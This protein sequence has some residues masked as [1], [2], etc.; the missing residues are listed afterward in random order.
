M[1]SNSS[2]V[3]LSFDPLSLSSGAA[4][5]PLFVTLNFIFYTLLSAIVVL[6]NG[7]YFSGHL[8]AVRIFSCVLDV[9]WFARR[10]GGVIFARMFLE[11]EHGDPASAVTAH[12]FSRFFVATL[13]CCLIA[14]MQRL[15]DA[16]VGVRP[17]G[18]SAGFQICPLCG[19]RWKATPHCP[20]AHRCPLLAEDQPA[21]ESGSVN[22]GTITDGSVAGRRNSPFP[23]RDDASFLS[24]CTF[25]WL[26]TFVLYASQAPSV[27]TSALM[28]PP[29]PVDMP[30]LVNIAEPVIALWEKKADAYTLASLSTAKEER[31]DDDSDTELLAPSYEAR[32][33]EKSTLPRAL[34]RGG[35]ARRSFPLR[36]ARRLLLRPSQRLFGRIFQRFFLDAPLAATPAAPISAIPGASLFSVFLSSRGGARFMKCIPLKVA[37]DLLSFASPILV[38][39]LVRFVK[40]GS[41]ADVSEGLLICIT[42]FAVLSLQS[43]VFQMY[44]ERLYSAAQ[45]AA[46][47]AKALVL[48]ACLSMPLDQ[49]RAGGTEGDAIACVAVEASRAGDTLVFLHNAWGH[50]MNIAIGLIVLKTYVGYFSSLCT[51]LTVLLMIPLN[52]RNAVR[53]Q[54]AQKAAKGTAPRVALLNEALSQ[55]RLI[56]ANA[57]EDQMLEKVLRARRDE[58]D[59]EVVIHKA[60]AAATF[61]VEAST[62]AIA[63]VCFASYYAAGG[64]LVAEAL[65]PALA[66]IN[67]LKFPIWSFPNLF[68]TISRGYV[69]MLRLQNFLNGRTKRPSLQQG[70]LPRGEV[71]C[72]GGTFGWTAQ[73]SSSKASV[74]T[75][76][77]AAASSA[78]AKDEST[79]VEVLRNVC[80]AIRP[81][82]KVAVT[83]KVAAGKSTL[84]MSMLGESASLSVG[85][86]HGGSVAL[87][88][89][90]PWLRND[91]IRSNIVMN[92]KFVPAWYRKVVFAC[93]LVPDLERLADGDLSLVG[94]K[95]VQLS[96]GQKARIGLARA[97][98]HKADIY[99][100]DGVLAALDGDTQRHII[101]HVWNGL[102]AEKTVVMA[103]HVCVDELRAD[104]LLVVQ[105]GGGIEIQPSSAV[106][107]AGAAAARDLRSES[108]DDEV[109]SSPTAFRHPVRQ[110]K[111]GLVSHTVPN[112]SAPGQKSSKIANSEP[113]ASLKSMMWKYAKLFRWHA[114][115]IVLTA[116]VQQAAQTGMDVWLGLWITRRVTT[117][118][119]FLIVYAVLGVI[120]AFLSYLRSRIFFTSCGRVS[121]AM[122]FSA[123]SR[124][125]RAPVSYFDKAVTGTLANVLSKDQDTVD[126][127]VP[128]SVELLLLSTL[129]LGAIAIF[130]S[131]LNPLFLIVIPLSVI[132]F[133]RVSTMFLAVSREVRRLEN[134]SVAGTVAI[135]REALLGSVTI[136][137]LGL[138]PMILSEFCEAM[139]VAS[140]ANYIGV[141]LDRWVGLRLELVS[142]I[143]A[144]TAAVV[145]VLFNE[146]VSPAF[147]GVAVVNCLNTS[148]TLLMLC[149]RMGTFQVQFMAVEQ[150]LRL[151]EVPAEPVY[152]SAPASF[153]S[154]AG[155]FSTLFIASSSTGAAW[156]ATS[157]IRFSR[158]SCKYHSADSSPN[159]LTDLTLEIPPCSKIGIVGRSG[160]GKSTVFNAILRLVD[161]IDGE[162][163]LG[164]VPARS[165]DYRLL[166]RGVSIIPQEP[167]ILRGT[168]RENL[169]LDGPSSAV[170]DVRLWEALEQVSLRRKVEAC[171]GGLDSEMGE[172]GSNLSSGEKQ[173][174]CLARASLRQSKF[175]LL[176]EVTASVDE[177]TDRYIQES[178]QKHFV[179]CTILTIAHRV[180]TLQHCDAVLVM[181][182][183]GTLKATVLP[184]E[185][186]KQ[187]SV[188]HHDVE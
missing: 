90:Q 88:T 146:S 43:I 21:A 8:S 160:T 5:S 182:E 142:I 83:G 54:D 141:S 13:A 171:P 25:W 124:L 133:F 77:V 111:L 60:E 51:F 32:Q 1:S 126:H 23:R 98:Y 127:A 172:G 113:R 7:G 91:S 163:E 102:L 12:Y 143:L 78:S 94:D 162:I 123:C 35:A 76:T 181:G 37:Q 75:S 9:A 187:G 131:A 153:S 61:L 186:L 180:K 184:K 118:V 122:H 82:E 128:E 173:L 41:S 34:K 49:Q 26:N 4:S 18:F 150:V 64:E 140:Q 114:L 151:Q 185:L 92:S 119:S 112:S 93:A 71:R 188:F 136:R 139:D 31:D 38:A 44:L 117:G 120:A 20:T 108:P 63:V 52:K 15:F 11:S 79:F 166:R 177:T 176:D 155:V 80:L 46:V 116:V 164:G 36:L 87:C 3:N 62:A 125:F 115:W 100:L 72:S 50:P 152:G 47:S 95:G 67:L 68:T 22:Y 55:M 24:R 16:A 99:L 156:P 65:V 161:C 2:F 169:N 170:N 165:L 10:D 33:R 179:N 84:L 104:T 14:D 29:L 167:L 103:T 40:Q 53:I 28:I 17:L 42:M 6:S 159:C 168:W 86:V 175:L 48:H 144:T 70:L 19:Y 174:L 96:G 106:V 109:G 157:S 56:R 59:S 132:L 137:C 121:N 145:S 66:A 27:L 69:S 149:R 85:F 158:V 147:A 58:E 135:L 110:H 101:S 148:R 138:R 183:G 134:H 57:Y 81:G 74:S 105:A 39:R 45:E 178:I 154:S 97:V 73:R 129:R 30:S 89:E 130:N 107:S